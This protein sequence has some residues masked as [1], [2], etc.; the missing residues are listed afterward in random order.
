LIF[1]CF[2]GIEIVYAQKLFGKLERKSHHG[3]TEK[4]AI[5]TT[6]NTDNTVFNYPIQITQSPISIHD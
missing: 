3:D 2:E 4:K 5:F 1:S 6:D